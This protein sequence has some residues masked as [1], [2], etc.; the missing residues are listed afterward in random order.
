MT[1]RMRPR[2]AHLLRAA[3]KPREDT[4][5][6]ASP[7]GANAMSR[8]ERAARRAVSRE[9]QAELTRLLGGED[10]RLQ[11]YDEAR[12]AQLA[13]ISPEKIQQIDAINRDYS[14]L[15]MEVRERTRG[16]LTLPSDRDALRL[17]EREQ[18]AD[19][20]A[21]MTPD[22]LLEY[23][24][25]ASTTANSM[26]NRLTYFEPT[27]AEYRA[28]VQLQ[29]EI[30]RNFPTSSPS[31]QEQEARRAAERG[32]QQKFEAALKPERYAEYRAT[33]DGSFRDTL[34]VM[35]TAGFDRA[36]AV[37]VMG[38]KLDVAARADV[39]RRQRELTPVQRNEALAAL[40][41][42]TVTALTSKLGEQTVA[43]LPESGG[44]AGI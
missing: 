26:R 9:I 18:R 30:D 28:L 3:R 10:P 19:L 35:Q 20:A 1:Q 2:Y 16:G 37:G 11:P 7:L 13:F 8:E 32:L 29:L 36:M 31:A 17:L 14:E 4:Y 42:E 24:L 27:E 12:R 5:W 6:R 41:R 21:A 39:I 34:A 40:E 44:G 22:E 15:M 33:T 43:Q 25:R 23:E 38:M